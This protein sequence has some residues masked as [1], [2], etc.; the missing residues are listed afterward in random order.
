MKE[1]ESDGVMTLSFGNSYN[2]VICGQLTTDFGNELPPHLF[3]LCWGAGAGGRLITRR[4]T[5]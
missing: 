1:S 3:P 4:V 5:G 2:L